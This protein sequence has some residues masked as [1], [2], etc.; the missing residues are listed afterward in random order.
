MSQVRYQN[1][2]GTAA[3][4]DAGLRSYMLGVYNYMGL[5]LAV[6]AA[7]TFAAFT[8]PAFGAITR[9]LAFPAMLALLAL[10]WFGPRMIF[11]GSLGR[12]HMFYWAYVAT[13]GIAIAP[14]VQRYLGVDPS[15]VMKAFLTA[16]LTFGATSI[17]GYTTKTDL[18]GMAR[19]AAMIAFG[20]IIAALV[21]LGIGLFTGSSPGG[22]WFSF[23]LSAAFVVINAI[24]TAWETQHIKESYSVT[25][26]GEAASRKSVFGAF[27]L[28]GSF[29]ST[30]AN[31]LQIFGILG[32]S[33]E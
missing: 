4:Y 33:D 31:L 26:T 32:S 3:E 11:N 15:M 22:I 21:N 25:D 16:G 28:Y 17:W 20:L 19:T 12:A 10:G 30:F 18:T 27:L 29:V 1:R 5:G 8:I 6:A 23:F 9:V 13:W 7:I 24:F 2:A 14:L